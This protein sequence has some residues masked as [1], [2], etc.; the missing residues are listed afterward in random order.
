MPVLGATEHLST[1]SA[2]SI[3]A[4]V[5]TLRKVGTTVWVVKGFVWDLEVGVAERRSEGSTT[6]DSFVLVYQGVPFPRGKT[7]QESGFGIICIPLPSSWLPRQRSEP[8]DN[9]LPLSQDQSN[10]VCDLI[11]L[12]VKL[13]CRKLIFAG[14]VEQFDIGKL[15]VEESVDGLNIIGDFAEEWRFGDVSAQRWGFDSD[16]AFELFLFLFER[17]TDDC[18]FF[19]LADFWL[20]YLGSQAR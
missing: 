13:P 9:F 20:F 1:A 11:T 4:V 10:G 5:K 2:W 17:R 16:G 18:G 8:S 19:S 3:V 6:P 7:K 15:M 14:S 12:L